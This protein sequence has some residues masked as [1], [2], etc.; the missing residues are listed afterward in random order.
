MGEVYLARQVSLNRPVAL[1]VLRPDLLTKPA[2]LARFEAEA[3]PVAK[4]NHPNIVHVYTLG[5]VDGIRFIAME[6][7]Q[8]TNLKDYVIRKGALHL[9]LAISIMR[10]AG[11]AIAAAAEVGLIHRDIKPENILLTRKGR[12]K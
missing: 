3:T 1:K 12:V 10:Q 5:C 4:L 7:V 9:P 2:Y 8:G 6:Y 11:Q